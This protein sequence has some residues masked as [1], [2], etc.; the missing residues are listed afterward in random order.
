MDFKKFERINNHSRKTSE[1]PTLLIRKDFLDT[2]KA[3]NE[4]ID[5]NQERN[6]LHFKYDTI[7]SSVFSNYVFDNSNYS[8]HHLKALNEEMYSKVD[9]SINFHEKIKTFESEME[10]SI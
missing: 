3:T 2:N 4:V 10:E 9:R 7:N 8:Y 6:Q 5:I 1:I